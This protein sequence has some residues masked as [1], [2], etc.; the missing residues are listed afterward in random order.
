MNGINSINSVNNYVAPSKVTFKA[1]NNATNPQ[2]DQLQDVRP[3]FAVKTPIA[4]TKT[5]EIDF[6]YDTKAHCYKLANG[7]KVIIVPQEGETV[8]RSY[9]NTGSMNEPDNL[10]G[11]SHYIEH[12]LFNGSIG[13]ENGEFFKNV[14]K[15][16]ASTNASTGFAETNYF[17]SSNLLNSS[18]LENKIKMHASMLESPLFAVEK[19]EKEKGIVNSEINM[20][21]S[22]PENL[23]VNKMLKNL[24]GIKSTSSDLIGGTTDNI[25]NLTRKDVVDYFENNYYPANMVTVITGE[26]K[27]DET[28]QLI[29]KYFTSKKQPKTNRHFEDLKPIQQTVREDII[30]DK[31]TSTSSVVGFNGPASDNTKDKIYMLALCKLLSNSA[32]SRIRTKV[33]DLNASVNSHQ[34]KI[35]SNPKDGRAVIFFADSNENNS[36]KVLN[37]IFNEIHNIKNNPPTEKEMQIIKK[38]LLNSFYDDF[39]NSFATNDSIGTSF[40]EN[41][42][43][44]LNKFEQI[45][46]SMTAQD[47]V[48]TANKYLDVNKASVTVVHPQNATKENI[49]QN[50]KNVSF[51]GNNAKVA[52]NPDSIKKFDMQNN[53]RVIT[54]NSKTNNVNIL[55]KVCVD[56]NIQAKPATALVLQKLLN[57][58]T[59]NKNQKDFDT[60]LAQD[61]IK[62]GFFSTEKAITCSLNCDVDTLNKGF[63]SLKEV[64]D[65]PRFTQE[66]LNLAKERI[67][68]SILTSEKSVYDKLDAELFKGLPDGYTKEEI[69]KSLDDLTLDDVKNLYTQLLQNGKGMIAVSAPFNRMPQLENKVFSKIMT[70]PTVKTFEPS[71]LPETFKPTEETKVLTDTN[72]KNQADIVE[73]FK[74]KTNGNLKDDIALELMNTILGG[75]SSSRLFTDLR[76]KEKLAYHVKS[77]CGLNDDIGIISLKIGTTTENKET[78]EQSFDNV[79]K[80]ID[81]FNRHINRI[82]TEKVSEEELNN[83]KLHFKNIILND[84][85]SYRGKNVNLILGENSPY[86]ALR[87][88]KIL[89]EIDKITVDDIYS[90]ANY[91][92]SNKPTYSILATEN[93]INANKEYLD[94]L[95]EKKHN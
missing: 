65:S 94:S 37:I 95:T 35:S 9:V 13:M 90:C 41:D 72:F 91:V 62:K 12:N 32:V 79:K 48:E 36:E 63:D 92:F 56:N 53:Y 11:I 54:Q 74:F 38:S 16:G 51:T 70:L 45:V 43:E 80:S 19:L 21:T 85:H 15:M 78:G 7:Q 25:T 1:A 22:D 4:Y 52:I 88:N 73:A 8:V 46:N 58:G 81:G 83:A 50:Y 61:G 30:S 28:M 5:G 23:A 33:K 34:E 71:K 77:N 76:E 82:K 87:D 10:R 66:E 18:D 75:T 14:E 47:L 68:D 20:I 59:I 44:Q 26:V 89:E 93:T 69:L 3:D 57:E 17:I 29:S 24:Y 84:N 40:L 67:R 64:I 49:E 42:I 60:E 27:P 55:Y 86:G 2:I 31:A 39:E 6:P